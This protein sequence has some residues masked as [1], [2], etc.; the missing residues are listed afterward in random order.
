MNACKRQKAVVPGIW[1]PGRESIADTTEAVLDANGRPPLYIVFYNALLVRVD[2][3][4][5]FR[6]QETHPSSLHY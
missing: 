1:K 2:V 3:L 4:P 5:A 6:G